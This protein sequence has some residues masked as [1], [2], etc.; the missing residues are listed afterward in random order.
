MS[1]RHL[2]SLTVKFLG[3]EDLWKWE[4]SELFVS[5]R[6]RLEHN[7]PSPN[8]L[9]MSEHHENLFFV[10]Q[11]ITNICLYLNEMD[12]YFPSLSNQNYQPAGICFTMMTLIK[13][14]FGHFNY[15]HSNLKG[16]RS[17]NMAYS[18]CSL[19][20][21]EQVSFL[22]LVLFL[23]FQVKKLYAWQAMLVHR[24]AIRKLFGFHHLLEL[25]LTMANLAYKPYD[26]S[27][28]NARQSGQM[29]TELMSEHRQITRWQVEQRETKGIRTCLGKQ[30]LLD[31]N[32]NLQEY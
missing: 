21:I 16:R 28:S 15:S 31:R 25:L 9:L 8:D 2:S 12:K 30:G 3:G 17:S 27:D 18:I 1:S 14:N 4:S 5:T 6:R 13:S 19:T 11:F 23:G 10:Y 24:R 20:F 7:E 32:F 22:F 29:L 26:L